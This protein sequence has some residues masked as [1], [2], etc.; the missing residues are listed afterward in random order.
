MDRQTE[1]GTACLSLSLSLARPQS[2]EGTWVG[3]SQPEGGKVERKE[4]GRKD[5]P[6]RR[7]DCCCVGCRGGKDEWRASQGSPLSNWSGERKERVATRQEGS[8]AKGHLDGLP[9]KSLCIHR[10]F[11]FGVEWSCW[12]AVAEANLR[13]LLRP[14]IKVGDCHASEL[15]WKLHRWPKRSPLTFF[16]LPNDN[17]NSLVPRQCFDWAYAL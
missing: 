12:R 13:H 11:N 9:F 7:R 16:D 5:S 14:G 8:K 6:I 2:H 4:E 3:E 1:V 17:N 15:E 10:R